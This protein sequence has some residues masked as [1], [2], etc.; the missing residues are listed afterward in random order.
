[1]EKKEKYLV[2]DSDVII[3]FIKGGGILQLHKIFAPLKI[4]L[5]DKVSEE[6]DRYKGN[7]TPANNLINFKIVTLAKLSDYGMEVEKE[8]LHI[9]KL[10]F[11]GDGESACMAV[12]RYDSNAIIASSNIKDIYQYCKMHSLNYLT[13]MD[14]LCAAKEKNIFSADDCN[15]FIKTVI[16]N[17][18][19]LPVTKIEDHQCRALEFTK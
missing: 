17:G 12:A 4:I 5:L 19:T 13:T 8:Y 10:Q 14:F 1:M 6:L 11:K 3:H 2:I 16:E 18:S 15:K 7:K 9:K